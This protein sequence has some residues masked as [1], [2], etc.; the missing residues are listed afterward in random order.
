VAVSDAARLVNNDFA[1]SMCTAGL[2]LAPE[3]RLRGSLEAAGA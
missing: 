1:V 3:M 2:T